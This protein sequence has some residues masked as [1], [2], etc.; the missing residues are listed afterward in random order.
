[1]SDLRTA[2]QQALEALELVTDLTNHDDEIYEVITALRAALAQQDE[3]VDADA[4]YQRWLADTHAPALR[5]MDSQG[6][7]SAGWQAALAQQ[8]EPLNLRDPAVQKRLA[9]QWGYVPAAQQA[10]PVEPVAWVNQANLA[11][12]RLTRDR[13]GQGDTHTW[14]ETRSNYHG[15]PLY[16]APPQRRPLTDEEIESCRQKGYAHAGLGAPFDFGKAARA[17]E[18]A[19]WEKNH[20]QA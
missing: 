14:S 19:S 3:S 7:F 17:V 9:T 5:R 15:V 13:G 11:S 18:K 10:E 12:A 6:A 8:A 20:G 2:A 1:M 16:T 4:A